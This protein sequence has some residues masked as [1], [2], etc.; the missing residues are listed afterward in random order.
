MTSVNRYQEI[1]KQSGYFNEMLLYLDIDTVNKLG[2]IMV[3]LSRMINRGFIKRTEAYLKFKS[4]ILYPTFKQALG[5]IKCTEIKDAKEK[6]LVILLKMKCP[7][8]ALRIFTIK[9]T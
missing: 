2:T 7:W 4:I 3:T 1:V 5:R 9:Y 6:L 8:L